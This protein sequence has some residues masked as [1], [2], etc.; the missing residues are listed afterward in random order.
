M[1][2]AASA[3]HT[4]ERLHIVLSLSVSH[5]NNRMVREQILI[6]SEDGVM[7][8]PDS[9]EVGT[10]WKNQWWA[11]R[12]SA[13]ETRGT[14]GK[15]SQKRSS[16]GRRISFLLT[17]VQT[18]S[19]IVK[20]VVFQKWQSPNT[21]YRIACLMFVHGGDYKGL[22][23]AEKSR[24]SFFFSDRKKITWTWLVILVTGGCV[25]WLQNAILVESSTAL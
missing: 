1:G 9:N 17:V 15:R 5:K 16:N 23:Q 4:Y 21:K 2:S 6:E 25:L 22:L 8:K 18:V 14:L 13:T 3:I 20:F 24:G 10:L 19:Q 7:T 11:V 12:Q